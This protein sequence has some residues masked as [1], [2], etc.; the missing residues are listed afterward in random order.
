M[1]P[2]TD[3]RLLERWSDRRDAGAFREIAARY[4]A[5]V[6]ATCRRIL[7]NA[8]EAEDVTQEC[9]ETL[10]QVDKGPKK[11]LGAWL[12]AVATNRSLNRLRAE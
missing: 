10:A 9:F 12:H 4:A 6:Y 7:G 8:T 5:M 3:E 1:S 11:H 2:L